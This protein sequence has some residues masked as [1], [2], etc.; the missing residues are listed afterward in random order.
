[1]IVGAQAPMIVP[2]VAVD[3]VEATGPEDEP[4]EE[5][6]PEPLEDPYADPEPPAD[7][8][9]ED[10]PASLDDPPATVSDDE[11]EETESE[12]P[13][14]S[15]AT[16]SDEPQPLEKL[17][18]VEPKDPSQEDGVPSAVISD[19]V[20]HGK[21]AKLPSAPEGPAPLKNP[22]ETK[23]RPKL[24][25]S[26][27]DGVH[28]GTTTRA[29][30]HEHWGKP[31]RMMRVAGGVREL[32]EF[33]KLGRVQ[34][35]IVENVVDSLMVRVARPLP[36][37]ALAGRLALTDVEPVEVYNPYGQH[38]GTAYPERGVLFAFVPGSRP[39]RVFQVVIE[40]IDA[41]PF[42]SRAEALLPE[43][44]ADALADVEVALKLAPDHPQAHHLAAEIALAE[45]KLDD[46][47]KSAQHAADLAPREMSHRLLVARI[48]AAA[49]DYPQAI[50]RVRDVID[51]PD[52]DDLSVAKAY[53]QW[54]DYLA[55][56][57]ERD[58]T[59]AIER[60]Q[61]AIKLAE[62]LAN[63]RQR[64]VRREAKELLLDAHLA[65]AYDVG[66]GHWQQKDVVVPKWISRAMLYAEDLFR[67]EQADANV[68]L[69]IYMGAVAALS[70]VE[71]PP[72]ASQWI[73]GLR[74]LGRTMYEEA[75]DATYRAGL[76]W[77]LA[78]ALTDA[79]E[80]ELARHEADEALALGEM[81]QTL[82]AESQPVSGDL[83]MHNY[84]R[85][86][87]AYRM[88]VVHAVE[89]DDHVR[90]VEWF[91]RATP[92]L[93]RPVPAA[94]I[95][96]GTQGEAFV[97]MAVSYWSQSNSREALRLTNQ[98]LKLMEQAV[99]DGSMEAAALAI[100]YGN[101]AAMHEELGDPEQAK[102]CAE[103]AARYEDSATK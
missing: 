11:D 84:R 43:H 27:L 34:A 80:I 60:H 61:Q 56:S 24:D 30:L 32:Y 64:S 58:F 89:R 57:A 73:G 86:Y 46:A 47:L 83:P 63:H 14:D 69:R 82:F 100:P 97:S 22:A 21:P 95:D 94:S 77:K 35:T 16:A 88:G 26:T 92:L 50:S 7:D 1:M 101:L 18:V 5:S 6:P 15:P 17:P 74:Q 79:V 78:C 44:T 45:G 55:R 75:T 99:T 49:G 66:W 23:V 9:A 42:L 8:E 39:P 25:P 59:G 28:P 41:P 36:A 65:V 54:G 67:H 4:G 102:W 91:N 96:A 48:L 81:A 38:L 72:D 33:Q 93:E 29:E 19:E 71:T 2:A 70:G 10:A 98:G 52:V 40:A 76:C 12:A 85:G 51:Q 37:E 62:P 103:L 53:C 90:A 87:S 3:I 31:D 13:D 68:R 20:P